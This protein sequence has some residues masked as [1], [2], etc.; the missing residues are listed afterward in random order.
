[1][2]VRSV[3]SVRKHGVCGVDDDTAYLLIACAT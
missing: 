3:R 1:M 2:R